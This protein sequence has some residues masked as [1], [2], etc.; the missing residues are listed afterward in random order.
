MCRVGFGTL[1][2]MFVSSGGVGKWFSANWNFSGRGTSLIGAD[3]ILSMPM[4]PR[5]DLLQALRELEMMT[6]FEAV[7]VKVVRVLCESLFMISDLIV[8]F[9]H[10][11]VC[12]K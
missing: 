3:L 7:R 12:M 8:S 9:V 2:P 6:Q 11:D 1:F 4:L 5:I 10:R